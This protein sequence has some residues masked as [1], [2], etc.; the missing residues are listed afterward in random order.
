MPI[1]VQNLTTLIEVFDMPTSIAFYR[2]VIGFEV[3]MKSN[4]GNHFDWALLKMGDASLMLN[5]AYEAHERPLAADPNR[6]SGHGDTTL[7]FYC[8]NVDETYT[9][10]RSK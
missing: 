10:L 1:Q 8:P 3:V 6:R 5:T 2:D 4:P 7:F 9:Y